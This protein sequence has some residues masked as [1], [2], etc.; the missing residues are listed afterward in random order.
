MQ[1][2]VLHP[3]SLFLSNLKLLKQL[4]SLDSW[5]ATLP[6]KPLS[7]NH[8]SVTTWSIPEFWNLWA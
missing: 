2:V 8:G 7:N 1:P 4:K 3:R 5:K 6:G